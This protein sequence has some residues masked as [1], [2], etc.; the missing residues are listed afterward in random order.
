MNAHTSWDD[1]T[2]KRLIEAAG[3]MF[4]QH[5]FKATTVRQICKKADAS[6]SAVNYHFKDKE[7]LYTAVFEYAHRRAMEK[8]PLDWG[9]GPNAS[10]EE[11]LLTFI[12]SF[13]LRGLGGGFPA[14]HGK[15]VAVEISDPSG[16]FNKVAESSL[17]P[18]H[19]QLEAI[20]RELLVLYK[21]HD[22]N[23]EE[24][25]KICGMNVV[26]QC[27][28]QHHARQLMLFGALDKLK[29]AEIEDMA[30]KIFRFSLAG[31]KAM[32]CEIRGK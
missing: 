18:M 11:R 12:R 29:T 25:V 28:F 1:G 2:K 7:G 3:E 27:I 15:L 16:I 20:V 21:S 14:W 10:A 24:Y 5:G 32:A 8:Y 31:I 30:G 26:G 19:E 23:V 17:K 13:L 9:L 4:A 6:V 22:G